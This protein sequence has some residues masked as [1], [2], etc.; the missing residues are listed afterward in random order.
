VSYIGSAGRRQLIN[1]DPNQPVN[2]SNP[3][4]DVN[5]R[6][7]YPFLRGGLSLTST[8]GTSDYHGLAA[9]FEKRYSGGMTFTSSYTWGHAFA[10]TGTTLRDRVVV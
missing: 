1:W 5:S 3:S 4:A 2:S 6:R 8:F 10:N 9:K 7:A